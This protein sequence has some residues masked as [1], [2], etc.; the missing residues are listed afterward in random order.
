MELAG[1]LSINLPLAVSVVVVTV[2]KVPESRDAQSPPVPDLSG[3][4]FA[5][6]L[7]ALTSGLTGLGDRGATAG[8]LVIVGVGVLALV[9]FVVAE[10]RSAHPL[11]PPSLFSDRVF[12]VTNVMTLVIYAVLGAVFL[13]LVLQLQTV[14]GFSPAAAGTALL[15]VTAVLLAF[16][17]RAGALAARIGPRLPMTPGSAARSCRGATDAADWPQHVLAP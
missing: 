9:A 14:A 15:P 13:V 2:L 16:S 3:T 7:G 17:S 8:A 4:V 10:R 11:M 5:L 6:G 12:R 1:S